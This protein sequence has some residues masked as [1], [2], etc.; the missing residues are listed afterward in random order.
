[1]FLEKS[2]NQFSKMAI[3]N[4]QWDILKLIKKTIYKSEQLEKAAEELKKAANQD[5]NQ[6]QRKKKK[7][8]FLLLYLNRLKAHYLIL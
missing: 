4:K 2:D 5:E 6:R 8:I 3:A 1:M 7:Y